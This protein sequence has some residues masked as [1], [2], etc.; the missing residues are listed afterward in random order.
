MDPFKSELRKLQEAWSLMESSENEDSF[1]YMLY[2]HPDD[3]GFFK[4]LQEELGLSGELTESGK[5]HITIRYVKDNNYGPLVEY[6]QGRDLPKLKGKC[7]EFSLFGKD[8]DALVIEMDGSGLHDYFDEIDGWLT[9]QGFPKSNFPDYKP[10]ITL[11]YDE[12]IELPEWKESYEKEITFSLHI[13]TNRDYDEVYR[14][15]V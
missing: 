5:F 7:R 12:G 4:D 6:L 15:K 10:H 11:T 8:K 1:C 3:E 14:E 13:V 2:V 9:S